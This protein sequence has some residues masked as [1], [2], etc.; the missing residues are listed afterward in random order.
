M[1]VQIAVWVVLAVVIIAIIAAA[2]SSESEAQAEALPAYCEKVTGEALNTLAN[3][4]RGTVDRN[5]VYA[6]K[7]EKAPDFGL[8]VKNG[9]YFVALPW[10]GSSNDL[11]GPTAVM[12]VSG[13]FLTRG[14]GTAFPADRENSLRFTEIGVDVNPDDIQGYEKTAQADQAVECAEIGQR[15]SA[16]K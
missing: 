16:S 11:P 13:D 3:D 7:S 14:G 10:K 8:F 9:L 5:N 1:G 6:V 2:S 4:V 15:L 12:A